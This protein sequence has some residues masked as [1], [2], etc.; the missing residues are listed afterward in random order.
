MTGSGR[1]TDYDVLVDWEKRLAREG[2]FFRTLFERHGVRSVAD[3]GAG[4]GRHAILFSSWGLEVWAIDPSDEMLEKARAN[5]AR[6]MAPIR[7]VRGAFG[8]VSRLLPAPVDAVT[9]TGNAL[10]H[11]EGIEGLHEALSDFCRALR[12]GGLLVLHLLNHHRILARQ[13]RTVP[14]V[15]R[16]A[17]EGD[18]FFLRLMDPDGRGERILFDFV[19]LVRDA[20]VR[21]SSDPDAWPET[22]AADPSGGWQLACRRSVHTSLPYDV[23]AREMEA[24]GFEVVDLY[25]AHDFSPFR[26]DEDESVIAVAVRR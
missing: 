18:V 1:P 6:L 19:T 5:A 25:G 26:P 12:P 24:A 16:E 17:D 22:L 8:E 10:P 3:V 13:V 21:S 7:V 4:S 11:V 20:R 9:C 2:P 15:F 23:L 14:P